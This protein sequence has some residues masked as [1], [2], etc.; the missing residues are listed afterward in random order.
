M[1]EKIKELHQQGWTIELFFGFFHGRPH[2]IVELTKNLEGWKFTSDKSI[3]DA[4]E[5][6]LKKLKG[7]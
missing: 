4:F 1:L 3:E 6:A 5:K 7:E 2:W